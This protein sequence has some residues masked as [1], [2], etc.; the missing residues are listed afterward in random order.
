VLVDA[1][2][3]WCSQPS[4]FS[5]S[6]PATARLS[7][8]DRSLP[9]PQWRSAPRRYG[10]TNQILVFSGAYGYGATALRLI[11]DGPQTRIEPHWRD[12]RLQSHF[13]NLLLAG[14]TIYLSR[15]FHG[16][17]FLTA[18]DLKT[19]ATK[20][21]AREFAKASFL[22]ADGK[23]IILD[24]E[25]WL[26]LAKPNPDGSL[27]VLSKARPLSSKRPLPQRFSDKLRLRYLEPSTKSCH[28][29]GCRSAT[30]GDVG[31]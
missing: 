30:D 14:D 4:R 31:N 21:F 22:R 2:R 19:G 11:A 3:L 5:P 12:K 10:T 24:E 8:R 25:G 29:C 20:W 17:A 13:G 1:A 9:I 23:L 16:P 6:I 7:G 26:A 18:V 28:G 15:G 27:K